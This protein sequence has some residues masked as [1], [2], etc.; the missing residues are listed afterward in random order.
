MKYRTRARYNLR[1]VSERAVSTLVPMPGS[2][3]SKA[4]AASTSLRIAPM[5]AG[6]FSVHHSA[7]RSISRWARGLIRTIRDKISRN[8]GAGQRV[9]RRKCLP[10]GQPRPG[11][12][13]A[14]LPAVARVAQRTHHHAQEQ[15]RPFPL[16]EKALQRRPCRQLWF[17]KRFA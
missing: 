8:A 11:H 16:A 13:E 15:S 1:I 2:S 14:R 12:R 7:A 9:P 10:R 17:L 3:T 6:R 5:A 4:R